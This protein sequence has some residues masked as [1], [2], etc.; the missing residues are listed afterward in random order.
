MQEDILSEAV[1]SV[2]GKCQSQAQLSAKLYSHHSMCVRSPLQACYTPL[3]NPRMAGWAKKI[4][5][6]SSDA[7]ED[8]R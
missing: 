1:Q 2:N 6:V 7:G 8:D 4:A 3:G 5:I